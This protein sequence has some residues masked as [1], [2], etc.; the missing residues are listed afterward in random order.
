MAQVLDVTKMCYNTVLHE[1]PVVGKN[2][3]DGEEGALILVPQVSYKF[4][5]PQEDPGT[6]SL[7]VEKLSG[8]ARRLV[9]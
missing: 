2:A 7:D 4:G 3:G 8:V 5:V 6:A 1:G 9:V